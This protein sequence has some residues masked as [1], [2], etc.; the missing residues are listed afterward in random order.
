MMNIPPMKP[1]PPIA[2][3]APVTPTAATSITKS[4]ATP[5]PNLSIALTTLTLLSSFLDHTAT[6]PSSS[7]LNQSPTIATV[8]QQFLNLLK[9]FDREITPTETKRLLNLMLNFQPLNSGTSTPLSTPFN[10]LLS[11]LLLPKLSPDAAKLLQQLIKTD[12]AL[13][14]EAATFTE[15]KNLMDTL[16]Q[17]TGQLQSAQIASVQSAQD[18]AQSLFFNIPLPW[19]QQTRRIEA[20]ISQQKS[21]PNRPEDHGWHLKMLLPVEQNQHILADIRLSAATEFKLQFYCPSDT[22]LQRVKQSMP[23]LQTRLEELGISQL[24]VQTQLGHIP[25]TLIPTHQGQLDMHI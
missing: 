14:K 8:L 21:S 12:P 11:S 25:D 3:L 4:V 17:V 1:T 6:I 13:L 9:P 15:T 23:L 7:Q 5:E 10:Q 2:P 22:W 20:K 19:D 18:S 16:K 24:T